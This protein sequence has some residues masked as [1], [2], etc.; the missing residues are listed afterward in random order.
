MDEKKPQNQKLTYEQLSRAFSDLNIQY[1]KVTAE[2]RKALQ[3]LQNREFDYTSFFLQML[4]KVMDHPEMYSEDFTKW[5][6]DSIQGALTS[7][8]ETVNESKKEEEEKKDV[9]AS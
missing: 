3:A 5:C 6:S 9:P 4:F 8:A 7:F 1:Q 2:Y